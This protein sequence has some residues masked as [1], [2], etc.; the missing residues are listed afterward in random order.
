[1]LTG[2]GKRFVDRLNEECDQ[3]YEPILELLTDE[4]RERLLEDFKVLFQAFSHMSN[5]ISKRKCCSIEEVI[6]D[7]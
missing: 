1:M 2:S 4:V 3:Y 7:E 5:T 6:A